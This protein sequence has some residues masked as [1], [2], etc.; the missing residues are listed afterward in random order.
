MKRDRIEIF[1]K[2]IK[3]FEAKIVNCLR[4]KYGIGQLKI[5]RNNLAGCSN[6]HR[7]H[8]IVTHLDKER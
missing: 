7:K 3:N 6:S 4:N 2:D 1:K 8:F 5:S